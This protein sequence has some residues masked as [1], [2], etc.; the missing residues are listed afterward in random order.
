MIKCGDGLPRCKKGFNCNKLRKQ[1]EPKI[2][3]AKPASTMSSPEIIPIKKNPIVKK[4]NP[5]IVS[6]SNNLTKCGE[7]LPRCKKGYNCHKTRKLCEPKNVLL[8]EA[9]E[10]ISEIIIQPRKISPISQVV[11]RNVSSTRRNKAN[12]IARF[13]K[14]TKYTRKA[15]FLNSVCSNSGLCIAFGIY[16]DEIKKFFNG[17]SSFDYVESVRPIGI[18]SNNGFVY[19]IKYKHRG[20]VANAILKSSAKSNGDN[21]LYEYIVG[22]QINK[23]FYNR[24]PIFV[25]TYDNYYTYKSELEWRSFKFGIPNPN[26]KAAYNVHKEVDYK[27]SCEKSKHLSILVQH[28]E[29]ASSLDKMPPEFYDTE[30]LNSLYQIYYTLS[31]INDEYTHYDLHTG[32][33]LVYLPDNTKYIQ[34]IFHHSSGPIIAF[35]SRYLIKMIDYGRSYIKTATDKVKRDICPIPE[36]NPDCGYNYGYNVDGTMSQELIHSWKSNKSHDLRLLSILKRDMMR[37]PALS[38]NLFVKQ[39][40]DILNKVVF[41]KRF[42]TKEIIQSGLP[43]KIVNVNDAEIAFKQL[44]LKPDFIAKNEQ[45]AAAYTKMGDLHIYADNDMEYIPA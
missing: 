27:L 16:S 11:I 23:L 43:N 41:T 25:E 28:I 34:Y 12:V 4:P 45:Y 36:C 2:E 29:N 31:K 15:R 38:G 37:M 33:V 19:S 21:L 39:I 18:S 7:N 44:L 8:R 20:Y 24:Y 40:S 10:P 17:F 26:L 5:I 22:K 9:Q 35:K 13:M 30:F 32:N 14:Q 1:C 42:G 3:R 6:Q